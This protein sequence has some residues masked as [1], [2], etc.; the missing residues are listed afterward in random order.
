M[1]IGNTSDGLPYAGP[2]AELYDMVTVTILVVISICVGYA[3]NGAA[4]L[5]FFIYWKRLSRHMINWLMLNMAITNIITITCAS[6]VLIIEEYHPVDDSR[7]LEK[8]F[9]ASQRQQLAEWQ[10]ILLS[11]LNISFDVSIYSLLA[12]SIERW[13]IISGRRRKACAHELIWTA[14][15]VLLI[16]LGSAAHACSRLQFIETEWSWYYQNIMSILISNVLPCACIGVFFVA[17]ARW[18]LYSYG[19]SDDFSVK[20]LKAR[21]RTAR[22]LIVYLAILLVC[23]LP[24][25]LI[26]GLFMIDN[27][28]DFFL[29]RCV[30]LFLTHIAFVFDSCLLQCLHPTLLFMLSSRYRQCAVSFLERMRDCAVASDSVSSA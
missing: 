6:I 5:L 12:L 27:L 24:F 28:K 7:L 30:G 21:Y 20:N 23:I 3:F 4:V 25:T 11:I 8:I 13:L 19:A 26:S 2:T 15:V 10:L 22:Y 14:V 17:S 1:V 29:C 18:L 9:L 16:W